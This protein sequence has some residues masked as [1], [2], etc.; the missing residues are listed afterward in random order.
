M[1]LVFS[2]LQEK[3]D[4]IFF[5]SFKGEALSKQCA[6]MHF[7]QKSPRC[8]LIGACAVNRANTVRIIVV[9]PIGEMRNGAYNARPPAHVDLSRPFS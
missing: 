7:F 2:K 6:L 1:R 5:E 4:I 9:K 8:G 3:S